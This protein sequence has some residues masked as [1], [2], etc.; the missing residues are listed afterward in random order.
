MRRLADAVRRLVDRTVHVNAPDAEIERAAVAIEAV[1]DAL[2]P[3]GAE[4]AFPMYGAL[5]PDDPNAFLPFSP[6][7][8]RYNPIAPPLEITF[9]DGVVH[10]KATFGAAY[11]GP[12]RGVHGA[13]VAAAF[14]QVLALV[15]V[16]NGKFAMTGTLTV[17]YRRPTPLY[18]ELRFEARTDRVEGRKVF[19]TSTLHAGEELVAEAEGLFISIAGAEERM[20]ASASAGERAE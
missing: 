13:I 7:M 2:E 18:T 4:R 19:A 15:N 1:T 5:V 16:M 14:D 3:H 9:A 20:A 17:R 8:G 10:A 11:E 6:M 12:P